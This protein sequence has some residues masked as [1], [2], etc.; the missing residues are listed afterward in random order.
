MLASN[1]PPSSE[2]SLG[3]SHTHSL[4]VVPLHRANAPPLHPGHMFAEIGL[5][6]MPEQE[7]RASPGKGEGLGSVVQAAKPTEA[8][9]PHTSAPTVART[10]SRAAAGLIL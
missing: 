5:A 6:N 2:Y 9:A 8:M 3:R 7:P 10:P 1:V 4:K